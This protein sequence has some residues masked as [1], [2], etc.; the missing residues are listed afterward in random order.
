VCGIGVSSRLRNVSCDKDNGG[1]SNG[2]GGVFNGIG[3][4]KETSFSRRQKR[5]L[6]SETESLHAYTLNIP[7]IHRHLTLHHFHGCNSES[8]TRESARLTARVQFKP[9]NYLGLFLREHG[10][11]NRFSTI[12]R[13]LRSVDL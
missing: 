4:G 10:D 5:F 7:H 9:H 8:Y 11:A 12:P 1:D 2:G 6:Q 3:A 13:V